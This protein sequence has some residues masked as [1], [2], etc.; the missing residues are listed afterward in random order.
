MAAQKVLVSGVSGYV[1]AHVARELLQQGFTVR[2]TVRSAD[3]ADAVRKALS[4]F[5]AFANRLEFAIVADI[6]AAGAFDEAVKGVDYVLHTA[7]P[8]HYNVTDPQRDLIDPAVNGTL[9]VLRSIAAHGKDVKRVVITSSLAAIRN[10]PTAIPE[11]LSELDWNESAVS[12]FNSLKAATPPGVA[13]AASKTFAERAA[14]DFVKNEKPAFDLVTINPPFIFGPIIHPC[15]SIND[16]NTS[17]KIFADFYTKKVTEV[18]P[19]MAVGCVDVRDVA[20]AHVLAITNPKASGQRFII[21]SGPFTHEKLVQ[22]LEE[23]FPE[24]KPYASGKT[25]SVP[26]REVNTKSKEVLGIG[27]YIP[28]E[29]MVVDTIVDLKAKFGI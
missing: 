6:G 7:S 8:F 29:Q 10:S 4:P 2:G 13:Y 11:G 22:I 5:V 14:W 24:H 26:V 18:N 21:S 28:L 9:G 3:K 20:R 17:V 12:Q 23:K 19:V 1:G 15:A 25:T 27:E 16:L